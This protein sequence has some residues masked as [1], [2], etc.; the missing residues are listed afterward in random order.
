MSR[1]TTIAA[2][3][4]AALTILI[5]APLTIEAQQ[6]DSA[7]SKDTSLDEALLEDLGDDLFEGLDDLNT[8]SEAGAGDQGGSSG[9][10]NLLDELGEGEDIGSEGES[11]LTRIARQMRRAQLRIE[12]QQVSDQTQEIQ[13]DVVSK[14]DALIKELQEKKRQ[15]QAC[16][17]D[18]PKQGGQQIKQPNQ[19][20]D[21]QQQ[22]SNKPAADSTQRLGQQNVATTDAEA[23][24]ALVKQV[25]GH[26]PDRARQE[27]QNAAVED[28]LPKYQ[29]VIEDYYRRLA[30]QPR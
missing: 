19:P 10:R 30:E 17:S 11:E 26:L 23:L 4:L 16:A 14:L 21:G 7:P 18:N 6:D 1:T 25:W 28:F 22:T 27:M 5:I 12:Q 29:Q 15:C 13:Q 2:R 24:E 8:D 3:G 9:D 20:T